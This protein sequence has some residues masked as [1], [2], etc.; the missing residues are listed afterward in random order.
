MV[1]HDPQAAATGDRLIQIRD[2]LVDGAV[3]RSPI[4][5]IP[6]RMMLAQGTQEQA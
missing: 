1:T 3:T 2:G 4:A 6:S 5:E